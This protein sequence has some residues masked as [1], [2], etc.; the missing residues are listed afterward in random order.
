ME[1]L[2]LGSMII[3]DL[4]LVFPPEIFDVYFDF[5]KMGHRDP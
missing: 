3:R 5:A 1:S 4:N 2:D